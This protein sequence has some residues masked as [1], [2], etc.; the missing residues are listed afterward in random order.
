MKLFSRKRT[1]DVED[2]K[3]ST[4]LEWI[5]A[6]FW[7]L[8]IVLLFRL[9]FFEAFTIPSSSMEG[10]LLPG[11]YIVVS[12]S[13][14]GARMPITPIAVPFTH[15]DLPFSEN[16][17]SYLRWIEL[18][19]YRLPGFTEIALND[20]VVFNYPRDLEHPIDQR[21]HYVKR[22]IA[23]PG[24]TFEIKERMVFING[25][26]IVSPAS[27]QYRYL[28]TVDSSGI[29]KLDSIG[30]QFRGS[31]SGPGRYECELTTALADSIAGLSF[32]KSIELML[33]RKGEHNP[34]IFPRSANF[35]W[36]Q[37]NFGPVVIPAK[38]DT[39]KLSV[40]TLPL[41]TFLIRDYEKNKL[42]VK[43]DSVFI[44]NAYASSYVVKQNY[45]FMMGDNR[46]MSEDSRAWGFLPEDHV[47]GKAV[48]ILTSV[49]KKMKGFFKFRKNR[50]FR[51][52]K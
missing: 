1:S 23:L 5:G 35:K 46:S 11:D 24:D 39:L 18:P 7:A 10:E 2:R 28:I 47:A 16:K 26:T 40:D 43:G 51:F 12:K 21:E 19:Y 3:D 50:T 25:K 31:L 17:R 32:V 37:D 44:N 4:F 34:Y 13:S 20:V 49:D 6:L 33:T 36:N 38:G 41:Y 8:L 22:C 52:I 48:M 27:V 42:Y 14:Y 30:I 45:Y 15:R 29:T 9:I